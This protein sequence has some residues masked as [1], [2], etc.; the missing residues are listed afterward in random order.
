MQQLFQAITFTGIAEYP[1]GYP[2]S[3]YFSRRLDNSRTP[4]LPQHL[5]NA[6]LAIG[7]PDQIVSPDH[8]SATPAHLIGHQT[9]AAANPADHS[10][11]RTP[12]IHEIKWFVEFPLFLMDWS[13]PNTTHPVKIS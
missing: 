8:S 13:I 10:N 12:V 11:N 4:P 5:P 7:G 9:L 3:V 2:P 6:R 1:F